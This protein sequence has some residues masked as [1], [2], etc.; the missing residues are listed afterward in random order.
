MCKNLHFFLQKKCITITSVNIN[1][2]FKKY[3][4]NYGVDICIFSVV[5]ITYNVKYEYQTN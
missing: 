1:L 5:I 2:I 4:V 3:G